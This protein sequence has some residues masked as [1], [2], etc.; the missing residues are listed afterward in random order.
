VYEDGR[1]ELLEH[2]R[3]HWRHKSSAPTTLLTLGQMHT[4]SR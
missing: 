3:L 4:T 1:L 2:E